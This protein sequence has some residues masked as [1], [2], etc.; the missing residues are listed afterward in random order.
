[1]QLTL[2]LEAGLSERYAKLRECLATQI[3]QRGLVRIAGRI[4][5]APSKLTE[6]LAG[7][8]SSGKVRGMTLDEFEEYITRENDVTPIF[9]LISKYCQDPKV[10]QAVALEKL[11]VLAETLPG[12]LAAAGFGVKQRRSA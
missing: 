11:A 10:N 7:M 1:M 3:Y 8:D 9:Y 5:M 6:K 2:S 4:D 12:L